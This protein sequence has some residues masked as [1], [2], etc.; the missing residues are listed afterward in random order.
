[1]NENIF[2]AAIFGASTTPDLSPPRVFFA[3]HRYVQGPGQIS[4]LGRYLPL[5][6][7]KHPALLAPDD[8]PSDILEQLLTSLSRNGVI[9]ERRHFSGQCSHAEIEHHA[10]Y[11][12][13]AAV[14]SVI[15]VGGGKVIDSAK[16][17]AARL[18]VPVVVCPTLAST[19]AP[20]SAVSV[21]YD[22]EGVFSDVEY[23]CGN[24]DLVLVDTQVIAQAPVRFFVAGIADALATGYETRACLA[25]PHAR[26]M[27]GGR[28]TLAAAT[29]SALCTE[30]IYTH[31]LEAANAVRSKM[32][33]SA[34]EDVIE[35]NTLLSGTGFESGGLALAHAIAT[36]LTLIPSVE[37]RF[38]HG[39]MVAVG[40][41]TQLAFEEN[42]QEF[43]RA[44]ELFI[45]LK[46]PSS[47]KELGLDLE[48][49]VD[50]ISRVIENAFALPF[51]QNQ[52]GEL[53]PANVHRAILKV[54]K[55]L[56]TASAE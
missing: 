53:S 14:D 21:I 19:D 3:A 40:L 26:S 32:V 5:L 41:L 35:A 16:A 47:Y 42:H 29:I 54:D 25:N 17:I 48:H 55:V 31:A 27:L 30:T 37:R 8:L 10:E 9:C 23:F 22:E 4:Q 51:I 36:A 13:H 18:A 43:E 12:R 1:M 39:E 6:N 24:P 7:S 45:K 15:A 11:L 56:S 50:A 28:I 52:P 44:K 2:P 20:C 38:L 49:D 34:V 33:N 46:L